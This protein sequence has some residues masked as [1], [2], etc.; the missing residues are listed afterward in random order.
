ML[1]ASIKINCDNY[2]IYMNKDKTCDVFFTNKNE[3]RY[4]NKDEVLNYLILFLIFMI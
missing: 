1:I 3:R 2:Y 4:L